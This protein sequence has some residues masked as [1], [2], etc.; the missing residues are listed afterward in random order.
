MDQINFATDLLDQCF[1]VNIFI[2]ARVCV[3]KTNEKLGLLEQGSAPMMPRWRLLIPEDGWGQDQ[4]GAIAPVSCYLNNKN[5][6]REQHRTTPM[7]VIIS[8]A[9]S[10]SIAIS[11]LILVIIIAALIVVIPLIIRSAQVA[12]PIVEPK[13][14]N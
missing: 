10:I 12:H 8:M 4:G 13:N 2:V 3:N 6:P 14:N 7:N 9:I 1:L 11:V 5:R